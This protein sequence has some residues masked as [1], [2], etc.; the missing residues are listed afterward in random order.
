MSLAPGNQPAGADGRGAPNR[1]A[2]IAKQRQSSGENAA[3]PTKERP[4]RLPKLCEPSGRPARACVFS[5]MAERSTY[6]TVT[7]TVLREQADRARFYA[8]MFEARLLRRDDAAVQR[9][10]AYAAELEAQAAAL[11]RKVA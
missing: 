11:E 10:R 4:L 8:H 6:S 9:L 3:G 2:N 1:A 7:P 5:R